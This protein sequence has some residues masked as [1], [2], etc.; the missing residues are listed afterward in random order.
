M[1]FLKRIQF[2]NSE[3]KILHGSLLFDDLSCP[4]AQGLNS[5]DLGCGVMLS[6]VL[7]VSGG[8]F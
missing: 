1:P 8:M 3:F 2:L 4:L 6:L 5:E 7:S